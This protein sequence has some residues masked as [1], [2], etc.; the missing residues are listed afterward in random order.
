MMMMMLRI[1]AVLSTA[2]SLCPDQSGVRE[3]PADPEAWGPYPV[4]SKVLPGTL[5]RRNLT[6]EVWFPAEPG[7]EAGAEPYFSGVSSPACADL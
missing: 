3:N 1:A 7:S 4:S 2:W 6:V 5:T